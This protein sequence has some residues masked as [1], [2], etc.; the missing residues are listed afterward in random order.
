MFNTIINI[1][2]ENENRQ[3]QKMNKLDVKLDFI[4]EKIKLLP[5]PVEHQQS[6]SLDLST[7]MCQSIDDIENLEQ[8]LADS[9]FQKEM[10]T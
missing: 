1:V 10:V 9:C 5:E 2:K 3:I 4:I 6:K 8:K 7:I